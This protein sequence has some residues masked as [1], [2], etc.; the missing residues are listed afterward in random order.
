MLISDRID[1]DCI[2]CIVERHAERYIYLQSFNK[3]IFSDL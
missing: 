3:Q 1:L 2:D